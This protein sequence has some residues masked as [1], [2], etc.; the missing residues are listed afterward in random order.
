M[1]ATD[2]VTS[3]KTD[4]TTTSLVPTS[5]PGISLEELNA[6]A[7]MQTRVDRKYIVDGL[8][9]AA[10]LADLPAEASVLEIDGQREF[11]YDSVYFDTPNLDSYRLAATGRRNRYKVRTRSYLD[12]GDTFLEVK[13]EGARA[14]TVKERIPYPSTDR[15]YLNAAGR[16][17]V[18]ESLRG[19]IDQ[20][21]TAFEPVLTT[22]YRR[23]TVLLP[24]SEHNPV[25]S[26]M[27]IDT[28]LTWTPLTSRALG[29]S[30][31]Y[32]VGTDY[33]AA[34]MVIIETKS[35]SA[36]SVADKHLWRAGIRPAKISKFATGMAA[37]NPDLPSNKWNRTIA[38][39]LY[40]QPAQTLR[41]F[42]ALAGQ[43]AA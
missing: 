21:A 43:Q 25:D 8:Y 40:L 41:D 33:T 35:G 24:A 3:P 42:E 6:K 7:A 28:H 22:A 26:R 29:I 12:T 37:L 30:P 13:T 16:D 9:A 10:V 31:L 14:V 32:R 11:S 5:W 17:Y 18:E 38:R 23:T 2:Q 20:P 36:P 4:N 39:H 27:T 15:A 19:L 34:G 1:S